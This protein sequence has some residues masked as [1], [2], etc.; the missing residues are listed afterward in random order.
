MTFTSFKTGDL[1]QYKYGYYG[2][3]LAIKDFSDFDDIWKTLSRENSACY[4][5]REITKIHPSLSEFITLV[6][7]YPIYGLCAYDISSIMSNINLCTLQYNEHMNHDQISK[8]EK[9]CMIM[10][11]KISWPQ[12]F[13]CGNFSIRICKLK[14]IAPNG[15]EDFIFAC[16]HWLEPLQEQSY[17]VVFRNSVTDFVSRMKKKFKV[18]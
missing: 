1:V 16:E 5:P 8:L 12:N 17:A 3:I 15:T 11:E 18:Q 14:F 6:N 4:E 10:L 2:K 13:K 7:G 9:P